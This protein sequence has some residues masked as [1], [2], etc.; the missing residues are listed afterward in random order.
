MV[1][2]LIDESEKVEAKAVQ[3]EY[4]RLKALLPGLRVGLLHGRLRPEE[5]EAVM[6]GFR[7]GTV[8]VL[9]A[10]PVIEVGVDV[11]NATIMVIENAERFGLA[12]LHQLRGRI[13]RGGNKSYCVL[14]GQPKSEEGAQRLRVRETTLDGFK[15]AEE[16]LRLRGPGDILG[17]DQS[18]LPP[19]R[20][21]DPLRDWEI[22]QRARVD[23]ER[24]VRADPALKRYPGL[25]DFLRGDAPWRQSLASV[26]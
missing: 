6:A 2:P 25:R 11:P 7:A 8:Q 16:D 10:T 12:Q 9:V 22:L 23:A 20:F 24:L 21:G 26:S 15:I 18:G 19:L 17:T 3:Q 13:G 5:K 14:V 4:E 1:Y